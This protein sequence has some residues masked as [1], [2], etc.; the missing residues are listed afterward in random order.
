MRYPAKLYQHCLEKPANGVVS[1]ALSAIHVAEKQ[2]ALKMSL[3]GD[4][5]SPTGYG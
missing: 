1:E 4:K 2:G 5:V 3:G